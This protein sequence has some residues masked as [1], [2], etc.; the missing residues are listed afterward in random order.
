MKLYLM[1]LFTKIIGAVHF[2]IIVP[3]LACFV[4]GG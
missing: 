4:L 3:N 1:L 2:I